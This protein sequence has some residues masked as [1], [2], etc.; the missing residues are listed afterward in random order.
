LD[1]IGLKLWS[2]HYRMIGQTSKPVRIL[3]VDDDEDDYLII[4]NFMSKIHDS[5][6]K[7][8]WIPDIS[9]AARVIEQSIH[10]IYLIDYRL[11]QEDGLELLARFDLVKRPE[12][13]IIL[14]GAGDE[15]VE[16]KAMRM[17]VADYLVKST[18]DSELLSRVLHYSLQRK[19]FEAD[20]VQELMEINRS[21]DEFIALA[22]HQ[23]RTPATAVKQYV[24]MILEGYAGDVTPEQERFLR[25]AYESNE[26]QIQVVNDI[27]RVAKLDLKKIVL[28]RQDIDLVE[29]MQSIVH[30]L[31]SHFDSR[32]QKVTIDKSSD[33][34][35]APADTEY[36]RMALSNIVDNASKYTPEHKSIHIHIKD[37]NSGSVQVVISDQ[38]VGI[39]GE[40]FDRL[41]K[42]FSRI[43]NPLSVK[44]GGTGLGLYWSKEIIELHG[45][46]IEVASK[47]DQGTAFTVTLPKSA[48]KK[49][50]PDSTKEL[51]R[52]S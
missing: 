41:F 7:M 49:P 10:D 44:V 19:L 21:K 27:L 38:G 43:E 16:R 29:L 35:F 20:R 34:I 40:D 30:D 31:M 48:A 11:G 33:R 28:K 9:E 1:A 26:R 42:K 17:G 25:S 18:L 13:F 47:V 32:D 2:F 14:T 37:S 6:F 36:I 45:G 46:T 5:P 50:A 22:S 51:A 52:K 4:R 8:D 3:L 23:L 15:R 39:T 24:G 12:P